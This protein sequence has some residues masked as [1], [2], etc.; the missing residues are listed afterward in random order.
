MKIKS[1]DTIKVIA[2][3]DKG[4]TGKVLQVFPKKNRAS[5]EGVNLLIKHLRANKRDEKGQRVQFPSP[6]SL[7]NMMVICSKCKKEARIG[8]S[9]VKIEDKEGVKPKFK[10]HRIC[11]KCNEVLK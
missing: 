5:V 11:K 6:L 7:S 4:K 1:G 2:G 9:L 3:K 10:K 8:Y